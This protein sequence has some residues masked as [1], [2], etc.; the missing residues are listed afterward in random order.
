VSTAPPEVSVFLQTYQHAPYIRDAIDS[1]LDQEAPFDFELLIA[2]DGSTDGTRAI[3]AEYRDRYP[4]RIRLLLPERNLGPTGL[5]RRSVREL[6]GRYVA[7]LDGD[8]RWSDEGKLARQVRALREHPEWAAC[9]HDAT[10]ENEDGSLPERPYVP[11]IGGVAVGLRD[12]LRSNCVPALSVM[13]RGDLVRELPDWVWKSLWSDWLALVAIARHGDIGYLPYAMGVYRV[14]RGG[15]SAGLTRAAQLEEDLR[16]FKVLRGVVGLEDKPLVE[17][18]VRERHCQL[19]VEEA[20]VPYAGGVAV[21]GPPDETPTYLNGRNVWP[22]A[23]AEPGLGPLDERDR[24]GDLAAQLG[25]LRRHATTCEP[26]APH[27]APV[28]RVVPEPPAEGPLYLLVV[29]SLMRWLDRYSRLGRQLQARVVAQDEIC[30]LHEIVA[31]EAAPAPMGAL[32]ETVDITHLPSPDG[33]AGAHV[34]APVGGRLSDCH[35]VEVAGWAIGTDKPVVAIELAIEGEAFRRVPIGVRRPDLARAF[36]DRPGADVAGFQTTVSLVG[37]EA[38]VDIELRA[39]LKDQRRV[40]FGTVRGRRRWKEA[41][42]GP[43]KPLV[44]VVVPCYGQARFLD[45]AIESVLAQTYANVE[46]V[47]VDDGSPDNAARVAARF[48]GVRCVRQPNKG[49]AASRNTGI[50]ESDG[51]LLVFLDSDDRLLPRAIELGVEQLRRHPE[52][53]FAFGR[54]RRVGVDGHRSEGDDQPRPADSPYS[55]FLRYNYAGVPATGIFRRSAL[56]QVGNFDEDCAVAEDYELGLR[57][58]RQ[59]PVLPHGEHVAEYRVH[60]AGMSRNAATMLTTT[61]RVLRR[62]RRYVRNDAE[63]RTAYRAGRRFWREYYGDPLARQVRTGFANRE[64]GMA[65]RGVGV[66]ARHHPRGLLA[67]FARPRAGGA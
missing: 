46:I 61:L 60:G 9:F 51:E 65:L 63:L 44:S 34:D 25:R 24:S 45:E 53:A 20:G 26:G 12:L 54:Y 18:S 41:L 11:N 10:V 36:P 23:I 21:L 2:D 3:L 28:D 39:V 59:Y 30:A 19:L 58:S 38:E 66:L 27:F 56:E 6:R 32:L 49:L 42:D 48:P 40:P 13:A 17:A 31:A 8:D 4:D 15:V 1:V 5:F 33:L 14:H 47:I 37:T 29:G 50:R 55:L 16:L 57:L 67:L 43:A 64:W 22:L 62:Q 35:A 52:A 7:W